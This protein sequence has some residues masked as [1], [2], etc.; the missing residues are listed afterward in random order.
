MADLKNNS[1]SS[2]GRHQKADTSQKRV[3]H[4]H[5]HNSHK[6]KWR[7][8]KPK[9]YW[10]EKSSSAPSSSKTYA[11]QE[12]TGEYYNFDTYGNHKK[13][14]ENSAEN[15]GQQWGIL[16]HNSRYKLISD[17]TIGRLSSY[18]IQ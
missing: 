18:D 3:P 4:P 17:L 11:A 14:W 10:K 7:P 15:W 9:P 1:Q 2:V 5:A 8:Q 13:N 16:I 12:E 6:D